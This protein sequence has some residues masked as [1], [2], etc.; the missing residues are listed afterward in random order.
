M[1]SVFHEIF[2]FEDSKATVVRKTSELFQDDP[3]FDYRHSTGAGDDLCKKAEDVAFANEILGDVPSPS[4]VFHAGVQ[5]PAPETSFADLDFMKLLET[6]I[7]CAADIRKRAPFFHRGISR[8]L[9]RYKTCRE[10]APIASDPHW[11]DLTGVCAE[12]V[13]GGVLAA[14]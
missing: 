9:N 1:D 14:L 12:F 3:L 10:L 11:N 4:P 8:I 5:P 6:G 13:T 7:S 2:G